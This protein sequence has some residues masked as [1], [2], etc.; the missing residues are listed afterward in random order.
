LRRRSN[1]GWK[2]SSSRT[3]QLDPLIKP[4]V[5][6]LYSSCQSV[7]RLTSSCSLNNCVLESKPAPLRPFDLSS[8]KHDLEVI[9]N[10]SKNFCCLSSASNDQYPILDFLLERI[11]RLISALGADHC[12]LSEREPLI[13]K[14]PPRSIRNSNTKPLSVQKTCQLVDEELDRFI[15]QTVAEFKE[16]STQPF[17][18]ANTKDQDALRELWHFSFPTKDFALISSK[19]KRLGF[20]N[21][22]PTKDLRGVGSFGVYNLIYLAKR[23]PTL[24]KSLRKTGFP[25]AIAGLNITMMLF[26]L[27]GFGM[28][29]L[30]A[31][32]PDIRRAVTMLLFT[33]S[34]FEAYW[35]RLHQDSVKPTEQSFGVRKCKY[36]C[37]DSVFDAEV[38]PHAFEELYVYAFT[39]LAKTWNQVGAGY[40]D[41]PRVLTATKG[42][43]ETAAFYFFSIQDIITENQKA[44]TE[45]PL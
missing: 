41:F 14:H 32:S 43:I 44:E 7:H 38:E 10:R 37:G 36:I 13:P 35:N 12:T 24:F 31:S 45:L 16:F 6:N 27:I 39:S 15:V 25:F 20:Q 34:N 29:N 1:A 3:I 28:P 23:Y 4:P 18:Y 5:D 19:W 30:R 42:V 22:D 2:K 9:G 11:F 21:S 33:P 26:S 17:N 8:L 40:M